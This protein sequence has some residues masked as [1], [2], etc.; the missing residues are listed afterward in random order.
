MITEARKALQALDVLTT[1][2]RRIADGL[3]ARYAREELSAAVDRV[4]ALHHPVDGGAD[5]PRCGGCPAGD[6]A[7]GRP[8]AQ[9]YPCPTVRALEGRDDTGDKR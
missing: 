2:V 4:R 6:P 3:E 5:G 8:V 7:A 1:E 9:P